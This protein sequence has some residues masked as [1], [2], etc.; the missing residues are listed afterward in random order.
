[1]S[2]SAQQTANIAN[3]QKST[4]PVTLAGKMRSAMNSHS[5][6]LCAKDIVVGPEEG[7]DYESLAA[8]YLFDL[9]P[10]GAVEVTLFNEILRA[11]WQLRRVGRMETEACAGRATYTELLDDEALQKKLDRLARHHTRIERTLHRCLKEFRTL[12][13]LRK[14]E[15]TITSDDLPPVQARPRTANPAGLATISERSQSAPLA[16]EELVAEEGQQDER[17][18]A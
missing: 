12:Q 15:G 1:M 7:A 13:A 11:A 14:K 18:A 17:Q 16:P 2:T 4:G 8:K 6:G 3:A 10:R 9:S 5:H